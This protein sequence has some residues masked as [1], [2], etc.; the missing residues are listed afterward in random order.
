LKIDADRIA[1]GNAAALLQLGEAAIRDGDSR[2]DL[3]AV[4]RCDSSAVAVLLAWQR[5]AHSR[6]LRLDLEA[7]PASLC[8]LATLYG[9]SSLISCPSSPQSKPEI[10]SSAIHA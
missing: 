5:A 4:K 3:S 10:S 9:V 6:G 2:F 7:V 1:N 8:S